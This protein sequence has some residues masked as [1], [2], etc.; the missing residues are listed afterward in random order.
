MS[1]PLIP[2]V[3]AP[4]FAREPKEAPAPVFEE[5]APSKLPPALDGDFLKRTYRSMAFFCGLM[6]VCALFGWKPLLESGS[7]IGGMALA[8][9]L[10][11]VQE[12]VLR[13]V[14]RPKSQL[15]GFDPR[16]AVM[17]TLPLKYLAII[18]LLVA[19]NS[20]GWLSPAPLA[21]GFFLAQL[22]IV[23]KVLGLM[24]TRK[25]SQQAP[26]GGKRN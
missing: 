4:T 8:A 22:V 2:P 19:L 21:L 11:R 24:A 6:G 12:T 23:A 14:M 25:A 7:F 26:G 13:A 10:L 5:A 1:S 15:G 9:V 3:P 20:A 17:L 18:G 16:L